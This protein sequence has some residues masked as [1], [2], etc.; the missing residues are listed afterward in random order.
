MGW[1]LI[2]SLLSFPL[3]LSLLILAMMPL[4][5][6]LID[7]SAVARLSCCPSRHL[8]LLPPMPIEVLLCARERYGGM[9]VVQ[10]CLPAEFVSQ[11]SL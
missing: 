1:L 7:V 4:Q 2:A 9:L 3:S 6:C 11:R 5:A 10:R 8:H